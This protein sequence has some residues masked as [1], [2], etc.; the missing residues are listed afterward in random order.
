[1]NSRPSL[2]LPAAGIG[3]RRLLRLAGLGAAGAAAAPLLAA[4]GNGV[5]KG[6]SGGSSDAPQYSWRTGTIV[7]DTDPFYLYLKAMADAVREKTSGAVKIDVFPNSQLGT[8]ADVFKLIQSGAVQFNAFSTVTVNATIPSTLL[9]SLPYLLDTSDPAKMRAIYTGAASDVQRADL[10]K[11]GVH[12]VNFVNNG[13]RHIGGKKAF[14][15]PTDMA[16]TKIRVPGTPLYQAIFK[17][18]GAVPTPLAITDVYSALQQGLVS[19]FEQ[20]LPGILA[21]KWY[22]IAKQITLA[23]YTITPVFIGVNQTIW[24]GLPKNIQSGIEDAVE[25]ASKQFDTA[26]LPAAEAD[27]KTKL[28]AAGVT[29]T[30]PDL[31][32][33][34]TA[35]EPVYSQFAGQVGGMSVIDQVRGGAK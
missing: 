11:A 2:S 1:M 30:S 18:F 17:Q 28:A 26:T 32:A 22:E 15:S 13:T 5:S 9:Y 24:N 10:A 16:G 7:T 3:R 19:A 12:V 6:A 14:P 31:N 21:Q 33:W 8:E 23:A 20:P 34:R 35:A 29:F 4:C 25:S 27:A